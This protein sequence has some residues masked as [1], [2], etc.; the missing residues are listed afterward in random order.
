MRLQVDPGH[1]HARLFVADGEPD[2]QMTVQNAV[3]SLGDDDILDDA[4]GRERSL[5]RGCLR[6][7][8][9]AEVAWMRQ[10]RLRVFF[11]VAADSVLPHVHCS[12]PFGRSTLRATATGRTQTG[13]AD[14]AK[15]SC[16]L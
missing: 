1:R 4:N 9:N 2:P 11:R 10:Q 8:V 16:A 5:H 3:G 6:F 7:S 15:L 14:N 13:V 12:S